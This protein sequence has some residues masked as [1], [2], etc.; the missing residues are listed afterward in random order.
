MTPKR[1]FLSI[2]SGVLIL[3]SWFMIFF[4]SFVL[5]LWIFGG[6]FLLLPAFEFFFD[7]FFFCGYELHSVGWR[8][9]VICG[10]KES[11]R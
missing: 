11:Y 10:D 2:E 9:I 6:P 1:L 4:L 7:L 5:S 3:D 8:Y